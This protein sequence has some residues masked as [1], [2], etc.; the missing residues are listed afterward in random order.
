[1]FIDEMFVNSISITLDTKLGEH[2]LFL[3]SKNIATYR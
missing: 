1:M 3:I 2:H